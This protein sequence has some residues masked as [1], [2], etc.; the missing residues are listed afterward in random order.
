LFKWKANTIKLNQKLGIGSDESKIPM[1]I[2]ILTGI[3]IKV[4]S[5]IYSKIATW[6]TKWENHNKASKYD[7]NLSLKIVIFEFINNYSSLY[8]IAFLKE[9]N[10][11]CKN[12]DCL[13]ELN[14]QIYI[15][16]I[17]NLFFNLIEIGMPFMMDVFAKRE[18]KKQYPEGTEIDF[19]PH[20]I[21]HQKTSEEFSTLREDYNEM[22]IQ[23]G[24]LTFFS[25]AAP[26]T[27]FICFILT[28]IEKFVDSYK[29][30][31]LH[32][33][34]IIDQSNGIGL[35]NQLF[36]IWCFIGIT[37]NIGLVLF[38]NPELHSMGTFKKFFIFFLVEN[39]VILITYFLNMNILPD[40]FENK[41]FITSLYTKNY[42]NKDFE[43]LPHHDL[44]D[45]Y[46]LKKDPSL[47]LN[48]TKTFK[49]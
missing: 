12:N 18:Y 10:E 24:Y 38:T 47:R 40:W 14:L 8:Y 13:S 17:T 45:K 26:I 25:V 44:Y 7:Y 11:G 41:Q 28:Y 30:F 29:L 15:I 32:R 9:S 36:K 2:G 37:T 48:R 34:T 21:H 16:L 6:L 23:F 4:S 35:Y 22:V 42:L 27:P 39:F 20:G 33:V 31:Y 5:F 43:G 49:K 3:Q 46:S 19:T 1:M